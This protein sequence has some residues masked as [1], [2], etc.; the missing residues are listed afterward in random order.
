MFLSDFQCFLGWND[1]MFFC[2]NADKA[3]R[4]HFKRNCN[5][6]D[7]LNDCE[8]VSLIL[9]AVNVNVKTLLLLH[10]IVVTYIYD[11]HTFKYVNR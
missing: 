2:D 10:K 8:Y 1:N 7:I 5:S 9:S 6:V 4:M 11:L 3:K